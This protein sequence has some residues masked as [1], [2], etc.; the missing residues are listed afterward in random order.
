MAGYDVTVIARDQT[1]ESLKKNGFAH[2]SGNKTS[3]IEKDQLSVVSDTVQAG[4]QD[5]VFLTVKV[6]ALLEI[7]P[8]L[9]PLFHNQTAVISLTNGIPPWYSYG[10]DTTIG[11][12]DFTRDPVRTFTRFVEPERI[13]GGTVARSVCPNEAACYGSK[14]SWH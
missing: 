6:G 3:F 11:R 2:T 8:V 10:Q 4:A 12:F 1:Y 7:A 13:I 5:Y 9:P 14:G